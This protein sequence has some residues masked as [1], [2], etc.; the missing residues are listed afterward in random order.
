MIEVE[1]KFTDSFNKKLGLSGKS[2]EEIL[3]QAID[4][5][6]QDAENTCRREAPIDTGN[7]RRSIHKNKPQTCVGELR[8]RANYWVYLQWGTSKMK[9]N[10]F[11]TRTAKS[12][13]PKIPQYIVEELDKAGVL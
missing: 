3:D 5:T 2:F 7:L 4:H 1:V 13:A 9:A 6:I 12:V 10:P 11:V 8:S